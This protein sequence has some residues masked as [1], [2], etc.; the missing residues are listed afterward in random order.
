MRK[1]L[2]YAVLGLGLVVLTS[3]SKNV[4]LNVP[5]AQNQ[6]V[7]EGHIEPGTTAYL[8]LSH[9]FSFYGTVSILSIISNDVIHGAKV[10]VSD[11]TTTDTMYETN[12]SIGFY[13]N[14]KLKGVA[15]KTYYLKV[16]ANGQTVTASTTLL[17]PIKL[18]SVWY[19]V[20]NGTDSLGYMW[21]ILNDPPAPGN[22]YRWFAKRISK[23]DADT[24]YVPPDQSVF[25]DQLINGEK[26]QFFY[27]R[28]ALPGSKAADD[29]NSEAG[30]FKTHDTVVVKFCTID[31]A[32]YKFYNTYYFQVDNSGNPFGSPAPLEGNI[33]GGLGIWCG[34]GSYL[35]TV[36]CK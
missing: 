18:D 25:N 10:T 4:T 1:I 36:V 8:Y 2:K 34:Y 22:C 14:S 28:G 29:T 21:A 19:K 17:A 9:N 24:T 3:C 31:Y 11:G 35:D 32:A 13:Q 30:Y 7:A 5:P 12:P 27:G 33:T 23:A 15:G 6:I 20:Q 26:F 16:I